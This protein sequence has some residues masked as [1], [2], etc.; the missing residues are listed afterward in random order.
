MDEELR[1][2]MLDRYKALCER[3]DELRELDR[4]DDADKL[5]EGEVKM[6][7]EILLKEDPKFN[8][9]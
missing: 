9:K 6:L 2:Y 3:V 1:S 4:E 7:L 8:V 5:L